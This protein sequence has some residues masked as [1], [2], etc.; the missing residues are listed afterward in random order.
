MTVDD[1]DFRGMMKSC[2][3]SVILIARSDA[4]FS[5]EQMASGFDV[6]IHVMTHTMPKFPKNERADA[7][8]YSGSFEL[9]LY[10]ADT[11]SNGQ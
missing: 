10:N 4:V 11:V 3:L 9:L 7:S 5:Y 2:E 8:P 1:L 6:T